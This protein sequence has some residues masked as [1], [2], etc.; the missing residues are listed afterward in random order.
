MCFLKWNCTNWNFNYNQINFLPNN[1][2]STF[3]KFIF[4]LIIVWLKDIFKFITFIFLYNVFSYNQI[5]K[6]YLC[7]F[8]C[9]CL[10]LF[11]FF[12]LVR[13]KL[14]SSI[15]I[16]R[17]Y[18]LKIPFYYVLFSIIILIFVQILF[19]KKLTRNSIFQDLFNDIY[20]VK[21]FEKLSIDIYHAWGFRWY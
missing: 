8:D 2:Y 7:F 5:W 11:R 16:I 4:M 10:F 20:Y 9:S 6:K 12:I 3:I 18:F 13:Q 14:Q 1:T 21:I 17:N 19:S 15:Y